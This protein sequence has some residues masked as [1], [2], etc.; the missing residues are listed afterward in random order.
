M[1]NV[2]SLCALL[3]NKIL[4]APLSSWI[5]NLP[6]VSATL[7]T[8]VLMSVAAR[9]VARVR[10]EPQVSVPGGPV[11]TMQSSE[12]EQNNEDEEDRPASSRQDSVKP[13]R[14][15]R[16]SVTNADFMYIRQ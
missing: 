8:D 15:D 2:S 4:A 11:Q 3:Q 14:V 16:F 5:R 9:L 7:S 6:G 10:L 1:L 13:L 12:E